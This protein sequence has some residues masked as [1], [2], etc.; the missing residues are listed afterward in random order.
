MR[1]RV[2]PLLLLGE[3]ALFT[4]LGGPDFHSGPE[5]VRYFQSYF[6][7]LLA[8]AAPVLLLAF[9]MT[10]IMATA[11]IDLSVGSLVALTSCVMAS[12]PGGGNF[13]WTA[14]PVGLALAVLLGLT[15]G[16]LI[17]RLD[18][19]PIIATLGTMILFRGLC[20]V[21]MGDLE[22][23]PFLDVP[24]YEWFGYFTGT[25]LLI[26]IVWL[27]G[28][29]FF[30]HSRWRREVLMIGG[31]RVAARY[32][33]IPVLRRLCEAYAL[34]GVLAFFAALTFTSRNGSMSAS[35]LTGLELRVIVAVVL[36]GT[37]VQGGSASL[38]GTLLG[39]LIIAV[40]DEGLRGATRWGNQHLAFKIS[41][42]QYILLG[43]LLVAGVWLNTRSSSGA[44]PRS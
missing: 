19:P 3:I 15:N 25:V 34:M 11:G 27:G 38:L 30:Q 8:Q 12:F 14:V 39:V 41:H 29:S 44:K 32:A 37:L 33:G 2:L 9:G 26:A 23:S 5:A 17:A 7:D 28:G 4:V 22:K 20:F 31:N 1:N 40:L 18:V 43:L 36:G 16:L 35:S 21:V 24:G 42:L 13:W 10:L 6:A